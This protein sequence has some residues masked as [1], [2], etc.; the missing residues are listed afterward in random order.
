MGLSG[1]CYERD[2]EN[3][4]YELRS[5]VARLLRNDYCNNPLLEFVELLDRCNALL[6]ISYHYE[7]YYDYDEF[8]SLSKAMYRFLKGKTTLK[9][10]VEACLLFS[11]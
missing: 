5:F 3:F 10:F 7:Q 6:L 11:V 9:Q 1:I 8:K 2:K 4:M